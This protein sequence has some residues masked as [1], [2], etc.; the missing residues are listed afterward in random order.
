MK[1]I[2]P[3]TPKI[4]VLINNYNY[5]RY[6]RDAIESVLNQDYPDFECIVVDDASTDHSPD[7]IKSYGNKI[8]ALLLERNGGQ[9]HCV[10]HGIGYCNGDIVAMLDADDLFTPGKLKLIADLYNR[11]PGAHVFCHRC[12][13]VNPQLKKVSYQWPPSIPQGDL[14]DKCFKRGGMWYMPSMSGMAFPRHFLLKVLPEPT[15]PHRISFDNYLIVL[16]ALTGR[17]VADQDFYTLRRIHGHNKYRDRD[18]MQRKHHTLL[19][20]LKRT[21]NTIFFINKKLESWGIERRLNLHT[22]VRRAHVLYWAGYISYWQWLYRFCR[23]DHYKFLNP[24]QAL[25]TLFR[26]RKRKRMILKSM[27][28]NH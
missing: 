26:I 6:L 17:V 10:N 27:G 23:Y 25:L 4:S 5:A 28:S 15:L 13:Q 3:H 2:N 9:A 14:R 11:D 18:R 19:D 8:T 16:A 1:H 24:Y 7:I 12:K 21:E 22:H 20:D